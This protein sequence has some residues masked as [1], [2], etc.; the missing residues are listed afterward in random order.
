MKGCLVGHAL[1]LLGVLKGRSLGGAGNGGLLWKPRGP[2]MEG[3]WGQQDHL[4]GTDLCDTCRGQQ[5]LDMWSCSCCGL[6]C[7]AKNAPSSVHKKKA[8]VVLSC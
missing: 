2:P 8:V 4:P 7:N 5:P 6:G 3:R 1:G